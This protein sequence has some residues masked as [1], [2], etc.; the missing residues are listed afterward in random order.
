MGNFLSTTS[1]IQTA[2]DVRDWE[3]GF[4]GPRCH[5]SRLKFCLKYCD[6]LNKNGYMGKFSK[7]YD[8]ENS[9]LRSIEERKF[10]KDNIESL[11]QEIEV[12]TNI[13]S[14]FKG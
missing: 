10:L 13:L 11:S 4:P 6:M 3:F 7:Q 9:M 8:I 1:H 5:V 12:M 14:T 2:L